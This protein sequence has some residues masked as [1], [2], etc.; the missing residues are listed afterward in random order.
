MNFF[1]GVVFR[2]QFFYESYILIMIWERIFSNMPVV[3]V[4][5]Y[6]AREDNKQQNQDVD[7]CK[8]FVYD[9][10]FFCTK[11]KNPYREN[12]QVITIKTL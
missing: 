5:F 2:K 4:P 7:C 11:C 6:E 3:D 8:N 1:V 9:G 12:T 10:R